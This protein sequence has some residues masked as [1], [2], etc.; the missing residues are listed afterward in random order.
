MSRPDNSHLVIAAARRRAASTRKRAVTALRRMENAGA[1]ITFDT[2]ARTGSPRFPLM[3]VQPGR[4]SRRGPA[5][6]TATAA[7]NDD[8]SDPQP[9]TRVQRLAATTSRGRGHPNQASGSREQTAPRCARVGSRRTT[10][11]RRPRQQRHADKQIRS[12]HRPTLRTASTTPS[13]SENPWSK[14]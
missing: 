4:S 13:S 6:P 7:F 10:R 3:A 12:A 5:T 14:A 8:H 1:P 11:C 2:V 9:A